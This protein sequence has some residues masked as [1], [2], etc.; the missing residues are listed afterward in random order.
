MLS[1]IDSVSLVTGVAVVAGSLVV[2]KDLYVSD[3]LIVREG[4]SVQPHTITKDTESKTH[5]DTPA[6]T[7]SITHAVHNGDTLAGIFFQGV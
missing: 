1:T 4:T 7:T 2:A 6:T 3:V 5:A